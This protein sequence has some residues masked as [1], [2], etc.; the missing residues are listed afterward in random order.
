MSA[1]ISDDILKAARMSEDE[2]KREIAILLY[3]QKKLSTGKARRERRHAF[4][5]VPTGTLQTRD[6]RQLRCRRFS[7]PTSIICESGVTCDEI[8]GGWEFS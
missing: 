7:F 4:H 3:Q 1:V 8:P 2:L 5:R 6:L